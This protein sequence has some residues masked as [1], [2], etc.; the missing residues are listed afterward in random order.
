MGAGWLPWPGMVPCLPHC[1]ERIKSKWQGLQVTVSFKSQQ[2][3]AELGQAKL[4]W[5]YFSD[6]NHYMLLRTRRAIRIQL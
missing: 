1:M 2:A 6:T 5:L 4:N 3:G